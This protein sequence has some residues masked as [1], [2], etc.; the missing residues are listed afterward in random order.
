VARDRLGDRE[1]PLRFRLPHSPVAREQDTPAHDEI[2]RQR[3]APVIR[4]LRP[5]EVPRRLATARPQAGFR[6]TTRL[7][8]ST[9]RQMKRAYPSSVVARD[10][11]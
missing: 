1:V 7:C 5:Q 2:A 8:A 6:A 4:V 11:R 3:D 10:D 9:M